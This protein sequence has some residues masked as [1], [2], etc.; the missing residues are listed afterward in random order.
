MKDRYHHGD[1]REAL[2]GAALAALADGEAPSLREVARRAGV[3]PSAVYHHFADKEA[4]VAEVARQGF[5]A[6]YEAQKGIV[7]VAPR[8]RLVE[9]ALTYVTFAA[10]H[11]AH[12]QVMF[13]GELKHSGRYPELTQAAEATFGALCDVVGKAAP[14]AQEQLLAMELWAIAHGVAA[15]WLDGPL[16]AKLGPDGLVAF[17]RGVFEARVA[18][19]E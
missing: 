2:V 14:T 15:L 13:R 17:A 11:P 1:L 7:A 8:E 12:F 3:A 5:V 18:A 4:L 19:L 10:A 9:L 6:L 16:Q